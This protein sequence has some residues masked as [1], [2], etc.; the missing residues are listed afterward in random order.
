MTAEEKN[1]ISCSIDEIRDGIYLNEPMRIYL[2]QHGDY[3]LY[4]GKS[5]DAVNRMESHLG[6]G[7]WIGLHGSEFDF[8][9]SG[10]PVANECVVTFLGESWIRDAFSLP[11]KPDSPGERLYGWQALLDIWV[12]SLESDLIFHLSPVFNCLGKK[13][14]HSLPL[15]W[16]QKHGL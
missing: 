4:V 15:E 6:I 2:V 8:W 5:K 11:V 13:K 1:A 7:E 9:L 16:R 14:D 12:D 3:C 10:S